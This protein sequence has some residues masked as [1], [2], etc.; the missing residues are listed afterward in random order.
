MSEAVNYIF[1]HIESTEKALK[2][3]GRVN[4]NFVVFMTAATVFM[5]FQ[6]KKINELDYQVGKLKRDLARK[7][8]E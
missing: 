4:R 5:V 6:A 2:R 1:N 7:D 3:Q 8:A